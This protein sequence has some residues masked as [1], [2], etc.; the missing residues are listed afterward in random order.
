MLKCQE[1]KTASSFVN[2]RRVGNG[3]EDN[4]RAAV[5]GLGVKGLGFSVHLGS[6]RPSLN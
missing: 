5:W 3:S 2:A 1:T 6:S 4:W